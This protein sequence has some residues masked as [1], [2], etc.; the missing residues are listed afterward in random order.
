MRSEKSAA[1]VS[2]GIVTEVLP[3]SED[4][5]APEGVSSTVLSSTPADDPA[6]SDD[7]GRAYRLLQRL[8]NRWTFPI[9]GRLQHQPMRFAKLKRSLQPISQRMLTL[10]L[11]HLERDGL[12]YRQEIP[13]QPP[14]V[15][16]GLTPLGIALVTRLQDFELWLRAHEKLRA[17]PPK[18]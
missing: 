18:D 8:A 13:G 1:P 10:S 3:E 6:A 4:A 14:Q 5:C 11:R 17:P 15:T 9:L 12:V 7:F 2:V 16:Y